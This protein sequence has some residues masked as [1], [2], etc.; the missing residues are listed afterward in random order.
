[1]TFCPILSLTEKC[2]PKNSIA[3]TEEEI[4]AALPRWENNNS[5]QNTRSAVTTEIIRKILIQKYQKT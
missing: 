2:L 4:L 1:M 3:M 5:V